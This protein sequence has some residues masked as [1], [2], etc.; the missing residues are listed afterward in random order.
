[1]RWLDSSVGEGG[2]LDVLLYHAEMDML[3]CCDSPAYAACL[4]RMK[5]DP[6]GGLD[7][8]IL[9]RVDRTTSPG[10]TRTIAA[11]LE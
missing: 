6:D 10:R 8:P 5:N 2:Y 3:Q 9:Y 1:M 4:T 7:L 11:L